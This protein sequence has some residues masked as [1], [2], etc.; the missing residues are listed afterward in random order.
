MINMLLYKN[1]EFEKFNSKTKNVISDV[2][3]IVWATCRIIYLKK[4]GKILK[5]VQSE[6][7]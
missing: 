4:H 6:C 7:T 3:W 5:I 2:E 1:N